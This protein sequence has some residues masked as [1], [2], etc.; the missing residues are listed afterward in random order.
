MLPASPCVLPAPPKPF[1]CSNIQAALCNARCVKAREAL[2]SKGENNRQQ[3]AS[4]Q[5]LNRSPLPGS[6]V[7]GAW[8]RGLTGP[9]PSEEEGEAEGSVRG[10]REGNAGEAVGLRRWWQQ[11]VAKRCA[12]VRWLVRPGQRHTSGHTAI[13]VFA[14]G[15]LHMV[16]VLHQQHAAAHGEDIYLGGRH[17]H[18]RPAHVGGLPHGG[19][20]VQSRCG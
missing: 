16:R 5:H 7:Y 10:S 17:V 9:L 1:V 8:T 12:G 15:Q 14:R 20:F 3:Q 11:R 18:L 6:C 13:Y 2:V 19:S 4:C